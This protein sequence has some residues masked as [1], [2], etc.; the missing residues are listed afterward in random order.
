MALSGAWSSHQSG[1]ELFD[2]DSVFGLP[3]DEASDASFEGFPDQ[4]CPEALISRARILVLSRVSSAG[5]A[6][7]SRRHV[8]DV[9]PRSGVPPSHEGS[10]AAAECDGSWSAGFHRDLL[11]RFLPQGS[12]VV[13]RLV[14]S[15]G[16]SPSR[17]F[18]PRGRS[19]H[20]CVRYR[21]GGCLWVT[22]TSPSCGLTIVL[23]FRSIIRSYL[24]SRGFFLFF[25]A[26]PHPFMRTTPLLCL[27]S[28]RRAAL[29]LR[30]SMR[31]LSRS[32]G[33][34]G[35]I[36]FVWCLSSFLVASM[37]S[38]TFSVAGLKFWVW[39]GLSLSGSFGRSFGDGLRP[40]I[41]L[42]RTS[43]IASRSISRRCLIRSQRGQMP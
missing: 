39:S 4:A 1:K 7:A 31:W 30:L 41:C 19:V 23:S 34:A 21:L 18:V 35:C 36:T 24:P 11:G 43:T 29:A 8:I 25:A 20:R 38:Q 42:R 3:R 22:T 17:S 40:S 27:I 16:G 28:T 6:S 10:S 32:C 13:V 12:L 5:L 33:S 15:V 9:C 2:S 26:A 14:P 37:C